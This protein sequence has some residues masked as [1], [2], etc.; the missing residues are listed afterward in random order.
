MKTGLLLLLFVGLFNASFAQEKNKVDKIKVTVEPYK[1]PTNGAFY[2]FLALKCSDRGVDYIDGFDFQ[3]G[4]IYELELKRTKL[5]QPLVDAGDTDYHLIKI[6]SKKAVTDSTTFI[7]HLVGW[8]QL[9]PNLEE[10]SGAFTF[11]N[12]GTC[13]Y[14]DEMTFKYPNEMEG[15]L[16]ALNKAKGYKKGTFIFLNGEI[17]LISL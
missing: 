7:T 3:W 14:L 5:A 10:D 9:A 13:T 17:H 12:D 11:N 6:I 15:K 1:R 2:T 8:V 4:Y 16:K